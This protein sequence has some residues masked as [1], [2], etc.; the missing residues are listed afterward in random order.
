MKLSSSFALPM[1]IAATTPFNENDLAK[2]KPSKPAECNQIDCCTTYCYG[3]ENTGINPPVG[4]KTCRGDFIF[5]VE[6]FY[7][8]SCEEGLDYSIK[9]DVAVQVVNPSSGDIEALNNLVNADYLS[10]PKHWEFGY[11]VGIGY[12]SECDGWDAQVLW[13][14]F[15]NRAFSSNSLGREN[16]QTLIPLWSAFNSANGSTTFAREINAI[17]NVN[18]NMFDFELGRAF[19]QGRRVS[20]RP[21]VGL[22]YASVNQDIDLE[23][24]GGSWSPR[25]EPDQDPFNNEVNITND[26]KGTGIR[27]GVQSL[28]H[29]GCGFG[30]YGNMAASL[31][32][33]R[34]EIDHDENNR[35]AVTP[36]TKQKVLK[37]EERFKA[38][39][40]ILDMAL[41]VQWSAFFCGCKY[42]VSGAIGWE[43]HLFFNQN[44]MWRITRIGAD[45]VALPNN[46]GENVFS[47][48][49]GSLSTQGWTLTIQFEF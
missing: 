26:F 22:R 18:L 33:G 19:W 20:I 32:Y 1:L 24:L 6:G 34:F 25:I 12:A 28:W 13:T 48:R 38:T 5:H 31:I 45:P 8:T 29:L 40:G 14:R 15:K 16:N 35:L 3:P 4:P 11:K 39:R 42:G 30:I 23:Q 9:N 37:T 46:T 47:K 41:G 21:H 44:Q 7:W 49:A 17:W 10:Y 27:S 2:C 43:H 36:Y